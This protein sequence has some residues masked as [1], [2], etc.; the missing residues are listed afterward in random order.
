VPLPPGDPDERGR[1]R[2]GYQLAEDIFKGGRQ[3]KT[4]HGLWH[5]LYV[6]ARPDRRHQ[7]ERRRRL[8]LRQVGGPK[9]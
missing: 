6:D 4:L 7:C 1:A 9:L 5:S 8:R 3:G 2:L